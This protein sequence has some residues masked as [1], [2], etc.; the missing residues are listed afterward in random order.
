MIPRYEDGEN[1]LNVVD[2]DM[3]HSPQFEKHGF[4]FGSPCPRSA[5]ELQMS[6]ENLKLAISTK[7]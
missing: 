1:S 4:Q 7:F 3:Q 2:S 5:S 6:P